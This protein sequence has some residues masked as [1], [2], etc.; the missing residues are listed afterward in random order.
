MNEKQNKL[1]SENCKPITLA[2]IYTLIAAI[3]VKIVEVKELT[4][5]QQIVIMMIG[6]YLLFM[7]FLFS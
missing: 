5:V 2:S 6:L 3:F 7:I 4:D 1:L